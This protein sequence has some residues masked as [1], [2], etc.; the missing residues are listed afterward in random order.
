MKVNHLTKDNKKRGRYLRA[1][2]IINGVE[3]QAVAQ[4]VDASEAL[5]SQ[6]IHGHRKGTVRNGKK[7][8]AI[9]QAFAQRLGMPVEELFPDDKAA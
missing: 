4:D 8:L 3:Q 9:K 6:V 2:L 7:I 1:L 5:V